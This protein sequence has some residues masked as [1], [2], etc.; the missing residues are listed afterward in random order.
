MNDHL[1]LAATSLLNVSYRSLIPLIVG[2]GFVTLLIIL[3]RVPVRYN[4]RNLSVRWRST[5]MTAMAFTM[6][7]ALM[8]VMLAFVN[9]M[10]KL[11]EQSGHPGNVMILSEGATDEAFS[12]LGFANVGNLELVAG[13]LRDEQTNQPLSS[14]EA[15]IVCN[16]LVVDPAPGR[17]RRRIVQIRGIEDPAMSARV[18]GMELLA[19]S[20][21]SQNG[22]IEIAPGQPPAVQAVVGEGLARELG[23]DRQKSL[24]ATARNKD[25]LDVGD[26]FP[27]GEEMLSIVG[28]IKATGSPFDSEIW[29]KRERIGASFGE[30][31]YSTITVRTAGPA[32][33]KQLKEFFNNDYQDAALQAY[34]ETEYFESLAR[35]NMQFLIATIVVTGILSIGGVFGVMNTMFATV[36]QRSKDIG[37]LRILGF[38]RLE[39]LYT[40][41]LE[42]L[43]LALFGG[44]LGCLLGCL[45]HGIRA[46]SVVS[47]GQSS[48][49][50]V[51]ELLVSAETIS[52]GLLVTLL[53]GLL[54][55]LIPSL[56][57]MRLRP[58][59]S[60]R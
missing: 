10:Y 41:L 54:G 42:S 56:L 60:L 15:Y 45:A 43:A 59:E 49:T 8:T 51:L 3:G 36:S 38:S 55:G 5:L 22:V 9:G 7:V 30:D 14:R 26:V 31:N 12:N 52:I 33:A 24:L 29:A 44:T 2:L 32:A 16:Q 47:G 39:V 20:W 21:F 57:A 58:L 17:P 1:L 23:R 11:T 35:T 13:I 48:K 6:V 46:T 50:V 19:G 18:H 28:I 4:V 37:V 34:T 40:F 25:R 27:L 53:M